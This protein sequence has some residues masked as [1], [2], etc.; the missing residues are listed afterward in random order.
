MQELIIMEGVDK[1]TS[2]EQCAKMVQEFERVFK[3]GPIIGESREL[4]MHM[5]RNLYSRDLLLDALG[6]GVGRRQEMFQKVAE[7]MA[8]RDA[9][10]LEERLANKK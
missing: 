1:L 3:T 8:K 2:D 10:I 7:M 5:S 4:L 9:K 6:F